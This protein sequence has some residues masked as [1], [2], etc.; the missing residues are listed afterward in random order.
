M[1]KPEYTGRLQKAMDFVLTGAVT[2]HDDG[3]ATVSSGSHTYHLKPECSC[4]DSQNRSQYCKHYRAV[5]LLK[6]TYE[7]LSQPVKGNG[8]MAQDIVQKAPQAAWHYAQAPSSCTLKCVVVK[9]KRT[10]H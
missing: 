1:Q 3:T 4:Q 7:R 10:Q 8:Q 5:Q 6:R 9:E 2:L